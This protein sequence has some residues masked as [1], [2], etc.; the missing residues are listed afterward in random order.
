MNIEFKAA[1]LEGFRVCSTKIP[2]S[3]PTM[4]RG[5]MDA[6]SVL[7]ATKAQVMSH[8]Q[9]GRLCGFHDAIQVAF[10]K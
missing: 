8:E 5:Q 7:L 9:V 10:E 2:T 1:Y 3:D 4:L 6:I